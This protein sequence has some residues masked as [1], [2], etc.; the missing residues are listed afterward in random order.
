MIS[1]CGALIA[2]PATASYTERQM[3]APPEREARARAA[4]QL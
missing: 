4:A 1:S 3:Q 2:A